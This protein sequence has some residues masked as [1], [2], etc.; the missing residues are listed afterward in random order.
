MITR[1]YIVSADLLIEL[2]KALQPP[3]KEVFL[4]GINLFS[5]IVLTR[6]IEVKPKT[7]SRVHVQLDP[8]DQ[9]EK[10]RM[11][12]RRGQDVE[13]IAHTHPGFG[14]D[15]TWPSEIDLGTVQR[16]EAGGSFI[17][18]IFSEGGRYVRFFNF[19]Q[20]S[21]VHIYG[22]GIKELSPVLFEIEESNDSPS[23]VWEE[24]GNGEDGQAEKAK[25]VESEANQ[26]VKNTHHWG[27]WPGRSHS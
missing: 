26:Q 21:T 4:T 20:R 18:L 2:S 11:L 24:V 27:W 19:D 13:A 10:H 16:W 25:M 14:V 6:F 22:K 23:E 8:K 15:S 5:V 7:S 17:G 9:N 3:E 12:L 1:S